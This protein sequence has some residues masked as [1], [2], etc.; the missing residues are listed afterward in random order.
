MNT[1][2]LWQKTTSGKLAHCKRTICREAPRRLLSTTSISQK[3]SEK[4][5]SNSFLKEKLQRD[6][7]TE[8]KAI[9]LHKLTKNKWLIKEDQ[10]QT[11]KEAYLLVI[12]FST[13]ELRVFSGIHLVKY[14]DTGNYCHWKYIG[15]P[16]AFPVAIVVD[17]ITFPFQLWWIKNNTFF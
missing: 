3:N 16:I 5:Y 13:L 2:S 6:I 8:N 9:S 12:D 15:L 10:G 1:K 17:I 14:S 4:I 11:H 7:F